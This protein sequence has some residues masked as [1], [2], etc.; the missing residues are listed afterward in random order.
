MNYEQ[1]TKMYKEW[2]AFNPV[3]RCNQSRQSVLH[4]F[5]QINGTGMVNSCVKPMAA[6]FSSGHYQEQTNQGVSYLENDRE[7][8]WIMEVICYGLS[9]PLSTNEQHEAVRDCVQ[10]YCEWLTALTPAKAK[11]KSIPFPIREDA[12]LYCRKIIEHLY[13]IFIPRVHQPTGTMNQMQ[14]SNLLDVISRQAL[15]CHRIL[16]TI[17]C[18]AHDETNF[19]DKQ[20]WDTLLTFLLAVNDTLLAPPVEPNDIGTQLSERI[21]SV[22]F[23]IWIIACNRCF[24]SPSYWKTFQQLCCTWRHRSALIDQWNSINLVLTQKLVQN[25]LPNLITQTP[26]QLK[27]NFIRHILDEMNEETV[28][29]TWFRFLHT[30]GNP[31]DLCY[32]EII[33][34]TDKFYHSAC[35]SENVV[36]PRQHPCLNYLPHIF[37]KAMKG[38]SVLVDLFLG[39][40]VHCEDIDIEVFKSTISV[41]TS[42]KA[43]DSEPSSTPPTKQ[44]TVFPMM[45]KGAAK[46][47]F[48]HSKSA[49][50][51]ETHLS[52]QQFNLPIIIFPSFPDYNLSPSR[53]K[54]TSI[55]DIFGDWLFQAALFGLET[56]EQNNSGEVKRSAS[57]TS[58]NQFSMDSRKSSGI[59][60]RITIDTLSLLSKESFEA[61]QAEAIGVLCRLFCFKRSDEEISKIL[62]KKSHQDKK[63][64]SYHFLSSISNILIFFR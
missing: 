58:F 34:K 13:N 49:K 31:V 29:Q 21:V 3:E 46:T 57:S 8:L 51:S 25:I 44:K 36:D 41:C 27:Q 14:E 53:P 17:E 63:K 35:A 4:K 19:I 60:D 47:S 64:V 40:P 12:N 15:L 28:R 61:G 48:A 18:V 59:S 32:P 30:I 52:T 50:S 37:Y 33:S 7:V 23:D 38:I 2:A 11:S 55:L 45:N 56:K 20:T 5:P 39:I 16:R 9:M 62:S 42:P 24:P 6:V 1:A 10:L 43:Q 22:L 26:H 54:S